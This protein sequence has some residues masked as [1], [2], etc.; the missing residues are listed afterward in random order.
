MR[1][2]FEVDELPARSTERT[3][4]RAERV[5]DGT[6]ACFWI[7]KNMLSAVDAAPSCGGLTRFIDFWV[8]IEVTSDTGMH[9]GTRGRWGRSDLWQVR[10]ETSSSRARHAS[11]ST[12]PAKPNGKT[13]VR[14]RGH[15]KSA[16][17]T[18][19]KNRGGGSSGGGGGPR[20]GGR[21]RGG[22]SGALEAGIG[23]GGG[24]PG[25][26]PKTVGVTIRRLGDP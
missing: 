26:L 13:R 25:R 15:G 1:A 22:L 8:I 10:R 3:T 2:D 9:G 14:R 18:R 7:C 17:T 19:L 24:T 16:A 20:P 12:R 4:G 23:G 11:G 21:P 6:R 5:F